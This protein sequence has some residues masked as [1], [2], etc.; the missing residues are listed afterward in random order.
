[1]NTTRL[2]NSC[3][4]WAKSC[5]QK[6]YGKVWNKASKKLEMAHRFMYEALVGE[7]PEGFILDHLCRVRRCINPKHLEP[8]TNRE[9][10]LRG[11]GIAA[12]NIKKTHCKRGHL[13]SGTNVYMF[14]NKRICRTCNSARGIICKRNKLTTSVRKRG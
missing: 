3:W 4:L 1:M 11:E 9:N 8:V 7:I 14:R 12:V 6:G 10:I 2:Q 5:N 13:L